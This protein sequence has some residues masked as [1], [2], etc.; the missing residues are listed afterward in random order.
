MINKKYKP[1]VSVSEVKIYKVN[2]YDDGLVAFAS[3]ILDDKYFLNGIGVYRK[4][5]KGY[6]ITFPKR[7]DSKGRTK[8]I[9]APVNLDAYNGIATKIIN[10][11]LI[12]YDNKN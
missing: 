10:K 9:F 4:L 1:Y 6:R 3:C 11:Y 7:R 5:K 8:D 12:M 2:D